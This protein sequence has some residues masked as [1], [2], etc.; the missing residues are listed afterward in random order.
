MTKEGALLGRAF[1]AGLGSGIGSGLSQSVTTLSTSAL[2]ATQSVD[3]GKV[4]E[5]GAYTGIGK[6]MDRLAQYYITLAEKTFPVIEIAAGRTVDVV[7]TKGIAL[8]EDINLAW[9]DMA[10]YEEAIEP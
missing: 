6:A 10:D 9:D 2:G 3:P 5:Y 8:E 1:I 7:L 4:L